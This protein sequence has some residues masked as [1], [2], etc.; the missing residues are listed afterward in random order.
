MQAKGLCLRGA[1][2]GRIGGLIFFIDPLT[3]MPHDVDVK[4]LTR[5]AVLY[6]IPLALNARTA[7]LLIAAPAL[8]R[9]GEGSGSGE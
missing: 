9:S 1:F 8:G 5:L 3:P 6:D 7:G 4:A 2:E